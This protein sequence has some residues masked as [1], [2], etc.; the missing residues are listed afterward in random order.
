MARATVH[1]LINRRTRDEWAKL[2]HSKWQ[3]QV[4]SIFEVGNLLEAAKLELDRGEWLAL[5]KDSLPFDRTTA[6]RLI[7]ISTSDRLRNDA[8]GQH[9]PASWRTLYELT[10][11]TDEQFATGIKTGVINP[12][13][14]RKDIKQ[15]LP[16]KPKKKQEPDLRVY[17]LVRDCGI[18]LASQCATSMRALVFAALHIA[19]AED[20]PGLFDRLHDELDDIIKVAQKRIE[21]G[22]IPTCKSDPIVAQ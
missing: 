4:E 16:E 6:Y 20:V 22:H 10:R 11:L 13:M 21:D 7:E 5:V 12:R 3:E 1:K 15:L 19:R 2:I 17:G 8:H 18:P 9:L 14:Q